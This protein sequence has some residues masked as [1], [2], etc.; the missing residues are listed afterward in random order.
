MSS[1]ATPHDGEGLLAGRYQLLDRLGNG[2]M[3]TVW[4]ARDGSLGR[5]VA[6]KEVRAQ[7]LGAH[8]AS[9]LQSRLRQEA[10]AA[11]RV[12]DP[13]V[14][15]V[16]DVLE[17]DGR[18]WIVM[19]LIDGPSLAD[20]VERGGPLPWERAA[21][22]G[23]DLL[24]TLRRAHDAGVLHRDV[25]PANVLLQ[26]SG[27]TVLTDFGIAVL[28]DSGGL[29]RSGDLIGSPEYLAPERAMGR[30]PGPPS[31]LWSL[32]VTLHT[33]VAGVS[34]FRR[35]SA[36]ST[37]HAVVSDPYAPPAAAGPLGAVVEALLRKEPEQR[38]DG[39]AVQRMLEDLLAGRPAAR[40][41]P[42]PTRT[43]TAPPPAAPGTAAH[44]AGTPSRTTAAHRAAG[45]G[46]D[47]RGT[48]PGGRRRRSPAVALGVAA[49]VVVVAGGVTAGVLLSGHGGPGGHNSAGSTSG[50]T[51]EAVPAT[52]VPVAVAG[53]AGAG[54]AVAAGAALRAVTPARSPRPAAPVASRTAG[55][56]PGPVRRPAVLPGGDRPWSGRQRLL[57]RHQRR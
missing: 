19:E 1:D 20:A 52:A 26:R 48:A 11:A 47:P 43:L 56:R 5:I 57:R 4:R 44:P 35:D 17:E 38:P 41:A 14:I 8:E 45:Y 40:A 51:G 21:R 18:P 54:P 6:V 10:R 42:A 33:A 30:H 25:K 3:G 32:G 29:T 2:G 22:L 28:D 50:G 12:E 36:I 27:R 46:A 37:L 31:D 15:T 9:V 53:P 13:G 34:P 55:G 16:Y 39:A 24:R 23:A 7:G 49:A